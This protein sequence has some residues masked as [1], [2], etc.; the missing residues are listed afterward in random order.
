MASRAQSREILTG[1]AP[2]E[3]P[4]APCKGQAPHDTAKF[5]GQPATYVRKMPLERHSSSFRLLMGQSP[6]K[7]RL[8]PALGT[9][10]AKL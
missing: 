3:N 7:A 1:A 6:R 2:W 5:W 4:V 10:R 9:G 8:Y